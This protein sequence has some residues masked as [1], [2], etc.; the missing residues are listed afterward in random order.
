M[1]KEG[2]SAKIIL[3]NCDYKIKQRLEVLGV[4]VGAKITL[5]RYAPLF[6]PI[7]IKIRGYNL[8]IRKSIAEKII[9]EN[10]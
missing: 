9:V 6:D 4:T 1:L 8:A 2:K 5:I 7:E 10:V 3:I